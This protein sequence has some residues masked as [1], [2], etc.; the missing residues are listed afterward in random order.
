MEG[1]AGRDRDDNTVMIGREEAA[2]GRSVGKG[3]EE[4]ERA[5]GG[6]DSM[7]A[8]NS[9]KFR[10]HSSPSSKATPQMS[11]SS[12]ETS[13]SLTT[14]SSYHCRPNFIR[15][16][17]SMKRCG[18]SVRPGADVGKAGTGGGG[19]MGGGIGGAT[20]EG[21]APA[22]SAEGAKSGGSE[23]VVRSGSR[24]SVGLGTGGKRVGS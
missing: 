21:W 19:R 5:A 7:T 12:V 11:S 9:M 6:A 8:R 22:D 2:K 1:R 13:W 10:S 24:G 18:D 3:S 17:R 23:R 14:P 20:S 4:D 16:W 15:T